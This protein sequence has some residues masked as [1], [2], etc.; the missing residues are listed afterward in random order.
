MKSLQPKFGFVSVT[1]ENSGENSNCQTK[2]KI[3]KRLLTGT[4]LTYDEI[5]IYQKT[6]L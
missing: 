1:N 6:G 5:E 2:I 4:K 3:A